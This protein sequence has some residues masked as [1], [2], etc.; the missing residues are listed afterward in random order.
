[1][2]IEMNTGN[3][4]KLSQ[5]MY[6]SLSKMGGAD[7]T[8]LKEVVGKAME[9]LAGANVKVT[10]GDDTSVA[11]VGE[12]KTTG[13]T[14]VPALDNP[15]D[16]KQVEAN[17]A[18]LIAFLQLDNEERQTQMAKDRIELQKSNLDVEHKERMNEID[19]SIKKM[20]D[21][22]KART[23]SRIFGWIGAVLAVAA[24]IALTIVTGGVAAGFA[25]AGAAIAVS[26]L[27]LNE[28]GAMDKIT[29][30]IV[31]KLMESDPNMS[32]S[33]AQMK[34]S[35]IVNLSIMAL[36]LACSIGGMA[37]GISAAGSAAANTAKTA[38]DAAHTAKTSVEVAKTIQNGIAIA[39][40]GMAVASL[41][42][43]AA[44]TY[45]T[46]RS[47]N[48]KADVT[49]LE[50]FITMLQQRLDES[51]EELQILLQQIESGIGKIAELIASATDTS[52]E[53][54]RNLGQMA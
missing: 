8:Q 31:D 5:A 13:A 38:V 9:V 47:E 43:G 22:E 39:N 54:A 41:G 42:A 4:P 53:I 25:I 26:S 17:L 24:A 7:S 49:E 51:Q 52:D 30:A 50:K 14:N 19:D 44:N 33:D 12:K 27:I 16:I 37:A 3:A 20:K 10:R 18:K 6:E 15:A 46:H 40:T 2:A 28:T 21:A 29:E 23:V 1:M 32:R 45:F 35:L 34:A 36:S 48:A 11:G